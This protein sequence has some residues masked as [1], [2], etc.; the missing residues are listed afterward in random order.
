MKTLRPFF[1]Y[2]GGKWRHARMY[3]PAPLHGT[4]VE[5]FA[6]SA[7]YSLRYPDR[8]VVLCDLDPIVAGVWSYLLRVRPQ[9]I[10][11]ISDVPLNGTVD[12]VPGLCQEARWLVG[13]WL[14]KGNQR[15][16]KTPSSWM[17]SG[18]YPG[19]FWGDRVR[20]TIASQLEDIRHWRIVH[21]SYRELEVPGPA[22]WFVD[23]PYKEMGRHYT[24]GSKGIDYAHLAAWCRGRDGQVIVCEA[25]GADWLPFETL[26]TIRT[27]RKD[28]PAVEAIWVSGR[29]QQLSLFGS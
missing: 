23:P 17:R 7:G 18:K 11:A 19:S 8:R 12:D 13:F 6:G 3:Y 20:H 5:P 4:I 14:N 28:R 2:Y 21:G 27:T 15:P 29:P 16:C 10:M 26:A 22:T 25:G 1:G 24:C 9:E